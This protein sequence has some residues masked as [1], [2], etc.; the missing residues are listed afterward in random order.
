MYNGSPYP[1]N[2]PDSTLDPSDH[3]A[4]VDVSFLASDIAVFATWIMILI[5]EFRI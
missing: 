1:P 3:K 4:Q 5:R 2:P